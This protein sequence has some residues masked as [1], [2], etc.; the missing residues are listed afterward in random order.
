MPSHLFG[1]HLGP[2]VPTSRSSWPRHRARYASPRTGS[3]RLPPRPLASGAGPKRSERVVSPEAPTRTTSPM[4][5][6]P[7]GSLASGRRVWRRPATVKS[8]TSAG[9]SPIP[10]ADAAE[11]CE[12][13]PWLGTRCH[14]GTL[15]A[16]WSHEALRARARGAEHPTTGSTL[17]DSLHLTL[18]GHPRQRRPHLAGLLRLGAGEKTPL[19]LDNRNASGRVP[20]D[21][22]Q[23]R[24]AE[25]AGLRR[26]CSQWDCVRSAHQPFRGQIYPSRR[27]FGDRHHRRPD[28][29]ATPGLP[30]PAPDGGARVGDRDHPRQSL[31]RGVAALSRCRWTCTSASTNS[32]I[33]QES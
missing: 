9:S 7:T 6:A 19:L 26:C 3:G 21:G 33:E 8:C 30:A 10:N 12:T 13:T 27:S 31:D 29:H 25:P 2:G 23:F 24:R 14:A 16:R 11:R 18:A 4:A 22:I 32:R 17:G 1:A 15:G 5:S 20:E 28:Q